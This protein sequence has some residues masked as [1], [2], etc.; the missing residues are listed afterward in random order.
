MIQT[1][2]YLLGDI[3]D[4]G[5][6]LSEARAVLTDMGNKAIRMILPISSM[7]KLRLREVKEFAKVTAS[8]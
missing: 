1:C 7:K 2:E 3:R 6:Q 4:F 5:S 8:V